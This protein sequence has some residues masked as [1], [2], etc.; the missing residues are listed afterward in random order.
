MQTEAEE[1]E[2]MRDKIR[3]ARR[4]I[5]DQRDAQARIRDERLAMFGVEY[6]SVSM[7]TGANFSVHG[8]HRNHPEPGQ[9]YLAYD[10]V[11]CRAHL[12]DLDKAASEAFKQGIR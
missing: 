1:L 9:Y 11:L 12:R 6:C 2:A 10:R 7:G 5:E 8:H 3:E 4:E